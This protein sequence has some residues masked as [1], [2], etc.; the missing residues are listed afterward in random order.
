MELKPTLATR[1]GK[2][3]SRG[4]PGG[5]SSS[6]A[7]GERVH[8]ARSG[9]RVPEGAQAASFGSSWTV[10]GSLPPKPVALWSHRRGQH[11]LR[12][13]VKM[14]AG[15]QPRGPLA[16]AR[17]GCSPPGQRRRAHCPREGSR[18]SSG[19]SNPGAQFLHFFR[20]PQC[21]INVTAGHFLTLPVRWG[22]P[23]T[24]R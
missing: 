11:G 9:D 16:P 18:T 7:C 13:P 19:V 22:T 12:L 23:V 10:A 6:V 20:Q 14:A 15:A 1:G 24:R 17:G 3:A 5:R 2:L 21:S 8:L 4:F